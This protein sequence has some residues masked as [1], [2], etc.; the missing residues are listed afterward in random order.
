[1]SIYEDPQ[2]P[3]NTLW[4]R[5]ANRGLDK[6]D[7][8]S[9]KFI[10]FIYDCKNS[11]RLSD[12]TVYSVLRDSKGIL[13][14]GTKNGLNRYHPGSNTFTH[15]KHD[16]ANPH[17]LSSNFIYSLYEDRSGVIW[18]GTLNGGINKISNERK[19]FN[20]IKSLPSNS[21]PLK[22]QKVYSIYQ[23]KLDITWLGTKNGLFQVNQ[24]KGTYK[25]Y[26]HDINNHQSLSDN[27]I[28]S[29]YEQDNCDKKTFWIGTFNGLNR[30]VFNTLD[31]IDKIT[32]THYKHDPDNPLSISDNTIHNIIED[33]SGTLWIGTDN[34]FNRFNYST[35][36]FTRYNYYGNQQNSNS[37]HRSCC[38]R[39][40]YQLQQLPSNDLWVGTLG[41]LIHF[42]IDTEKSSY[43]LNNTTDFNSISDYEINVIYS[44]QMSN[45]KILWLGFFGGI[46]NKFNVETGKAIR[47]TKDDGF[48]CQS[49]YGVL[50]DKDNNLWLSTNKGITKFNTITNA[51]KN[52]DNNDGIEIQP[53]FII[54]SYFINKQGEMFFGG[55]NGYIVFHPDSIRDNPHIPPIVLTEFMI[56]NKPAKLERTIYTTEEIE[57]SYKQNL[58]SFEFAALDYTNPVKNQYA[59]MLKG[60]DRN[61]VYS[62]NK[63]FVNYAHVKPGEYFFRVKGSNNDGVWNEEGTLI[64]III[65][66]PFWQ[67]WWFYTLIGVFIFGLFATVHYIRVSILIRERNAQQAFSQKLI[68]VVETGRKRIA[69]DLH[70]SLG[71]NLLITKNE[72]QQ[73]LTA[74]ALP[75]ECAENLKEISNVVSDS[76]K[77][78]R[79]ISYNLHPH[80][81]ERLGLK[82]AIDSIISK[83]SKT[84]NIQFSILI[85]EI[86]NIF[87][88]KKEIHIFRI[89]QES[90]NN[91]AKHSRATK[92]DIH[93]K[94][95]S[96]DIEILIKDNGIG[97]DFKRCISETRKNQGF[98]LSGIAERVKILNGKLFIEAI[99]K[100]GT[101][102]RIKIPIKDK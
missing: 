92:T 62:G 86:D 50:E 41:G 101:E 57:L 83:I 59:Y 22:I 19:K 6:F 27:R 52:Y 82:K 25:H 37:D 3:G 4:I 88:P 97:F 47:F 20:N 77:E 26:T 43:Y 34:G 23:D 71:Q 46:F 90:L 67:T 76:I 39:T 78:V 30:M 49:V 44:D 24:K 94:R 73:C 60:V 69:G 61:W 79:E 75:D 45:G 99:P 40:I 38:I 91:I 2:Y 70:D 56:L 55:Q 98:G 17:S 93:V 66:P 16:P 84:S 9:E 81:L 15:Y 42:N 13:W 48:T 28:H 85:D 11:N 7:I 1:M 29:I 31:N 102:L 87:P 36:T 8:R 96:T 63:R 95:T 32:Y 100:K 80:Q 10:E 54:N 33:K 35:E 89:I 65:T 14:I 5:T 58:F 53:P 64:K 21:N 72:I 12:N 74:K 68:E 51:I 18:I